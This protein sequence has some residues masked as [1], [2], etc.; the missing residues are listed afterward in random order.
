MPNLDTT[1]HL[2]LAGSAGVMWLDQEPDQ[3][4]APAP[5]GP[6][7]GDAPACRR[8]PFLVTFLRALAVPIAIVLALLLVHLP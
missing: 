4:P 6:S 3:E 2:V 1:P 5:A 7:K 8:R